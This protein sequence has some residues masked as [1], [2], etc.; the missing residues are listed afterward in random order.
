MKCVLDQTKTRQRNAVHKTFHSTWSRSIS[1]TPHTRPIGE[2]TTAGWLSLRFF[3]SQLGAFEVLRPVEIAANGRQ[4][5]AR[6]HQP[7]SGIE[8]RLLIQQRLGLMAVGDAK[9]RFNPMESIRLLIVPVR[10][11]RRK[12]RND[13]CRSTAA[14][15]CYGQNWN[16][17][18]K[19]KTS[20]LVQSECHHWSLYV[21][22]SNSTLWIIDPDQMKATMDKRMDGGGIHRSLMRFQL[23]TRNRLAGRRPRGLPFMALRTATVS[24]G[25]RPS[26]GWKTRISSDLR[27]FE[28]VLHARE[29]ST[30]R[31]SVHWPERRLCF[32]A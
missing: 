26:S 12:T 19:K 25:V 6:R 10:V 31:R 14:R 27:F 3:Y 1:D 7:L 11:A 13:P 17:F 2:S 22:G 21:I 20:R 16:A 9:I 8:P 24:A 32:Q 5:G 23:L 29:A 18:R 15:R 30:A 4:N 28:L